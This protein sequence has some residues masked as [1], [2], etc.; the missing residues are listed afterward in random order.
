[1]FVAKSVVDTLAVDPHVLHQILDGS[2]LVTVRPENLHSLMEDFIAIELF[3]S[4]HSPC[5][6]CLYTLCG[7]N[8]QESAP[9]PEPVGNKTEVHCV[10]QLNLQSRLV[11]NS[12]ADFA[13]YTPR[14]D[15]LCL[16]SQQKMGRRSITRTG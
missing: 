14:G 4:R 2:S 10:T 11:R 3:L 9:L 15:V 1:M 12:Q 7:T 16:R 8:S 13:R 5:L 6:G